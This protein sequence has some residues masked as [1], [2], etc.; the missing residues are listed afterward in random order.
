MRDVGMQRMQRVLAAVKRAEM[1]QLGAKRREAEEA[2]AEAAAHRAASRQM[3]SPGQAQNMLLQS[4]WQQDLERRA[5]EAEARADAADAEAVPIG[6][7]LARTLGRESVTTGLI[8]AA[9]VEHHRLLERRAEEVPRGRSGPG[10][11]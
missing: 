7:R 11:G 2:R 4:R 8:A 1:A 6:A 5:R 3:E 10:Q 9:K